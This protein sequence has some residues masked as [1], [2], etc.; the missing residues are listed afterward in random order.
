MSDMSDL[1]RTE[2]SN[3]S[4]LRP[5]YSVG[6]K[7][8]RRFVNKR[9]PHHTNFHA[10]VKTTHSISSANMA[11]GHET[12]LREQSGVSSF[13]SASLL[14]LHRPTAGGTSVHLLSLRCPVATM[15]AQQT[16]NRRFIS[17][18]PLKSGLVY[19]L[20]DTRRSVSIL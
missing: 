12:C 3:D 4:K 15:F 20:P 2:N 17:R 10:L 13:Q 6:Y 8:T 19:S 14:S 9:V 1:K 16:D 7:R 18:S 11:P 5:V